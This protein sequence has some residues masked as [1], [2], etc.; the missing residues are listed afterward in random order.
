MN[1]A[2]YSPDNIG[3]FGLGFEEYCHFTSPIRRYPDL[4]THR[5][6]KGILGI[7]GY[8]IPS[9]D[10]LSTSGTM[11]S[12]CELSPASRWI[13]TLLSGPSRDKT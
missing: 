9:Q 12:A 4:M 5:I 1:Q 11:L 7:P 2:K 10:T 6:T 3:H 8:A 13:A